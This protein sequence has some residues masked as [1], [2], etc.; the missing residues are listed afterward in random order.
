MGTAMCNADT[1][2]HADGTATAFCYCGWTDEFPTT[3]AAD[4]AAETHQRAA[5]AVETE[6]AA[7]H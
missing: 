3:D 4:H 2:N 1:I 5:D 7:A 6:C